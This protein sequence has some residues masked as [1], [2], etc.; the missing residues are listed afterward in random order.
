MNLG[1]LTRTAPVDSPVHAAAVASTS[2]LPGGG[3]RGRTRAPPVTT[4][5][6][7]PA[8][9]PPRRGSSSH[10]R[11]SAPETRYR[12]RRRRQTGRRRSARRR[13]VTAARS[14]PR[15]GSRTAT[16]RT[17]AGAG[18][19]FGQIG[20]RLGVTR[21]AAHRLVITALSEIAREMRE[22]ATRLRATEAAR[23]RKGNGHGRCRCRERSSDPWSDPREFE[24]L[25]RA[26]KPPPEGMPPAGIEP[27]TPGLGNL[28]SI[29]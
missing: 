19:I 21:Q 12:P 1:L 9:P 23:Q 16:P 27:A 22:E 28:C 29:H 11:W 5:S 20:G 26:E 25:R 4:I 17:R 24:P 6:D 10:R 7:R 13:S 3:L 15:P 2:A 14:A 8:N 18:H